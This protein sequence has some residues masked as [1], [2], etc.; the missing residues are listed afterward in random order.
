MPV[1]FPSDLDIPVIP[2]L[3]LSIVTSLVRMVGAG[4]VADTSYA[5]RFSASKLSS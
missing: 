4:L 2:G 1:R 3:A 5:A